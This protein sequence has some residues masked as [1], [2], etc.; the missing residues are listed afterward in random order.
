MRNFTKPDFVFSPELDG[1]FLYSLYEDDLAY[2]KEVF[3]SFLKDTKQEFEQIKEW[4]KKNEIKNIRH[5]LHKIKPT[6]SFVGLPD[7]TEKTEKLII[8]CDS[9]TDI[10]SIEPTCTDLFTEIEGSFLL[11]ENELKRMKNFVP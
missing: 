6:F 2:A 9:A 3:E 5:K 11:I 1:V 8:A 10:N 4:Y 7:I